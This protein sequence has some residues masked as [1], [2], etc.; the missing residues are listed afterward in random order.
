M[1]ATGFDFGTGALMRMGVRGR[2]GLKL[3]EHWA[4]GPSDFLGFMATGSRTSS[5]LADRTVPVAA[6]TRGTPP[7]R[8]TSSPTRSC[9]CA[10]TAT[11]VIEAPQSAEDAW[12]TM[13]NTSHR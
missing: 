10:T 2:D 9:T 8:S 12:M 5:S 4:D 1:W 13:V 7:T 11:R 3:E 6:T